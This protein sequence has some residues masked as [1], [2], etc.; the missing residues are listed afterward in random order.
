MLDFKDFH[1]ENEMFDF[2]RCCSRLKEL[3]VK[4]KTVEGTPVTKAVIGLNA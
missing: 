3:V 2:D 4:I 1:S